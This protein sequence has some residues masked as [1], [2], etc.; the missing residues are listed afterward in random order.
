MCEYMSV[1]TEAKI[2]KLLIENPF[3]L[4]ICK[5]FELNKDENSTP[6]AVRFS[7]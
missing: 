3:S 1:F 4:I 2:R 5:S 7:Q 6:E